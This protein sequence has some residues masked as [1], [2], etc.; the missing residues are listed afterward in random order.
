M[1]W[2]DSTHEH[3]PGQTN[4]Q[5]IRVFVAEDHGVTSWGL[6]RMLDGAD[7]PMA[8][9]GSAS[10]LDALL[11]HEAL[12]HTDVLLLDLDLGGSDAAAALPELM[13]R[14]PGRI[15]ILT[16]ND[17]VDEHRLAI[18]RGARGVVHKSEPAPLVLRAIA[19]VHAGEVWLNRQLM[20]E[21]LGRLTGQTP[22]PTARDPVAEKIQGLTRREREIIAALARMTG[23][24]HLA[25]A[26][27]LGMSEHTLRN[28]LTAIYAKLGVRGRLELHLFAVR[29]HL[30]TVAPGD[31]GGD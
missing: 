12:A 20:G 28:H 10:E 30:D 29:H 3:P 24:K 22:A 2:M 15:L 23:A 11:A 25:V 4:A 19:K 6:Q 14:C 7:P 1:A 16:G 31:D 26:D 13:Q 17:D 8:L 9:V 5:P 27:A 18:M 21:V